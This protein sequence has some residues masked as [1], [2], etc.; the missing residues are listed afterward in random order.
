ML[1][2]HL[3]LVL[4][5]FILAL[6]GIGAACAQD[7]PSKPIRIIT[8]GVGGTN[9]VA[10]RFIAHGLSTNTGQQAVVENRGSGAIPGQVFSKAA[11]DGYTLLVAGG[12]FPIR[13]LLQPTPYDPVRDFAPISLVA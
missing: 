10:A 9:D 7:Y 4:L 12:S 3:A 13:P 11:P 8:S 6:V 1:P 5:P 2:A